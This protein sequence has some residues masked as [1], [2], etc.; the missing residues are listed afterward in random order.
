M[1]TQFSF[2]CACH[3]KAKNEGTVI[4]RYLIY[5]TTTYQQPLLFTDDLRMMSWEDIISQ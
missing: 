2:S 1:N 3:I 4:D 5:S